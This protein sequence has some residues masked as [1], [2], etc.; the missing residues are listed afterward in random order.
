MDLKRWK[1]RNIWLIVF[2]AGGVLFNI[3][4]AESPGALEAL[5]GLFVPFV[6]L[7]PVYLTGKLGAG[8]V[9]LF[10]VAGLFL[11]GSLILKFILAAF[12]AVALR[13]IYLSIRYR[14]VKRALKI[15]VHI[16]V[17]AFAAALC[18]VGGVF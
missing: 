6:M 10:C 4:S 12:A 9:K 18:F 11:G 14:S 16:A 5:T 7:Y 8:D 17:Y 2:L 3:F 13:F 1:I 15:R